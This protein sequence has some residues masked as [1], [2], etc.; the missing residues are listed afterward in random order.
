M[1]TRYIIAVSEVNRILDLLS[2]DDRNKIP[3]QFREFLKSKTN[4]NL[5][6][7]FDASIPLEKQPMSPEAEALLAFICDKYF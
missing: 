3:S 7:K 1:E 6:N 2:E 5:G 4:E